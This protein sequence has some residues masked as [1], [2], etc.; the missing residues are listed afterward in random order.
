MS[1]TDKELKKLRNENKKLKEENALLHGAVSAV[2]QNANQLIVDLQKQKTEYE[3]LIDDAK[4][5]KA[6]YQKAV[7]QAH[8]ERKKYTSECQSLL[9]MMRKSNRLMQI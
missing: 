9:K 2:S 4:R 1:F 8:D 6:D 3:K 5:I 7:Q